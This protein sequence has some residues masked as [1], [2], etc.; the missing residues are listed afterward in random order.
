MNHAAAIERF[1]S[2][3]LAYCKWLEAYPGT[4]HEEHRTAT[5]LVAEL[6]AAALALPD[7]E[8]NGI[9][10]PVLGRE[11]RAALLTRLRS[12]PLQYYWEIFHPLSD[13]P[14][15]AVCGNITDDLGD[16]YIDVKEGL[17]AYAQSKQDA[18]WHW[19]TTFGLHWGAH[20]TSALRALHAFDPASGNSR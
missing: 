16:I 13:T 5:Y 8:P 1:S 7:T 11:Q 20:A 15:T 4:A 3:A 18:V 2:A 19:R 12:F 17:Y 6:Y 9:D 10:P 14:E